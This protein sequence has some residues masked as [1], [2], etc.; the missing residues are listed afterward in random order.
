MFT[1]QDLSHPAGNLTCIVLQMRVMLDGSCVEVYLGSGEV[2]STRIYRGE[3]PR[4]AD[5]GIDLVSWGG[6]ARVPAVHAW[7]MAS[8]WRRPDPDMD[9]ANVMGAP[10][11]L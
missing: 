6:M 9:A 7:E 3:A 2:M 5:A 4:G 11:P 1:V 8:I 10:V